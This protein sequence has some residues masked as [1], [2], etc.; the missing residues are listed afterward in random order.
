MAFI[1]EKP[2]NPKNPADISDPP[3][4]SWEDIDTNDY[5]KALFGFSSETFTECVEWE[6]RERER[7]EKCPD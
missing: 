7:L 4:S 3:P 2:V 1:F 5:R 6:K